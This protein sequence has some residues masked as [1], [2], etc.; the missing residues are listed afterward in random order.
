MLWQIMMF[1]Y[2]YM[3]CFLTNKEVFHKTIFGISNQIN[4]TVNTT[5]CS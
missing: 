2:T 1:Q 5:A 4:A 3:K